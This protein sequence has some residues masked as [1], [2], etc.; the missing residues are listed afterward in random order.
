E[1]LGPEH[2]EHARARAPGHALPHRGNAPLETG[3]DGGGGGAAA[4]QLAQASDQP[5]QVR[6]RGRLIHEIDGK[7]QPLEL[8]ECLLAIAGACRHHD[9]GLEADE[10]LEARREHVAHARLAPGLRRVVAEIGHA[11]Q[12]IL[13]ADGEEDLGDARHERD[14]TARRRRQGYRL[15]SL[16]HEGQRVREPGRQT[17][18]QDEGAAERR[19]SE[20]SVTPADLNVAISP[21]IFV[22]ALMKPS[23]T[24]GMRQAAPA[25]MTP[26]RPATSK[27]PT[28]ASTSTA[29]E[30]SGRLTVSARLITATLRRRPSSSMPVPAPVTDSAGAPVSAVTTAL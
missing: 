11:D 15:P 12:G 27:P 18:R 29:S 6:D 19:H 16:V 4:G 2:V 21:R 9:V 5:L 1:G 22:A 14:D 8:V 17:S 13:G 7:A 28:L 26:Q 3:S 24:T 25:R 30:G 23:S 10:R 20:R